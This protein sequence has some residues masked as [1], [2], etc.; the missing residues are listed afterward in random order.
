[1]V[2]VR[3]RVPGHVTN[4]PL[5]I[6]ACSQSRKGC[7]VIREFLTHANSPCYLTESMEQL[8]AEKVR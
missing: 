2:N 5:L 1:M 6:T 3:N 7:V 4:V 8:S